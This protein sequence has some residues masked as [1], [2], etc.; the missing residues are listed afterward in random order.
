LVAAKSIP[1]KHTFIP[2]LAKPP[3][4]QHHKGVNPFA[5]HMRD[6]DLQVSPPILKNQ[7]SPCGGEMLQINQGENPE[8]HFPRVNTRNALHAEMYTFDI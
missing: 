6:L 3:C 7:I 4:Q 1:L 2:L 5:Q 8:P